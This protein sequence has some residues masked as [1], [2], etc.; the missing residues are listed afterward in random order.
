MCKKQWKKL[1]ESIINNTVRLHKKAKDCEFS[2]QTDSKILKQ[3]I[4][5]M[6]DN[7]L[8]KKSIQ[9]R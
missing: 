2:D 3:L 8:I 7:G 4:Q 6:K 9:N 5:T 1:G